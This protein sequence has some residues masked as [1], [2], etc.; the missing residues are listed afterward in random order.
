VGA[1]AA[2]AADT[3]GVAA[4]VGAGGSGIFVGPLNVAAADGA[5]LGA[6]VADDPQAPTRI[7]T[8]AR[9]AVARRLAGDRAR[10]VMAE[11]SS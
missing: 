4:G 5:A 8:A 10:A 6:G 9:N 1:G 3:A 7:A 2:V 11:A